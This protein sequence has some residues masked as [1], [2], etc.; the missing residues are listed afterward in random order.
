VK[1]GFSTKKKDIKTDENLCCWWRY[2]SYS[3]W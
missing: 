3:D 2:S 1:S